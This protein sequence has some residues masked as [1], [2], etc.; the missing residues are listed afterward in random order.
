MTAPPSSP[1]GSRFRG[2]LP[3]AKSFRRA[4]FALLIGVIAALT[5]PHIM[6]EDFGVRIVARVYAPVAGWL[7]GT[8]G[9][10]QVSVLLIDDRSLQRAQ[11]SWPASYGYYA[12]LL[13]ALAQ[14]RP[15]A[16][17]IDVVFAAQ[18][19]DPSLSRLA[20]AT[21]RATAAGTRVYLAA[22]RSE[23][24]S[25]ALRP[26]LQALVPRCIQPVAI[27]YD[28]D[29][30]DQVAWSYRI[31]PERATGDGHALH[32]AAA[33]IYRDLGGRLPTAGHETLAL[34]W[35]LDPAA[36]GV[37]WLV[38]NAGSH[39]EHAATGH[40]A[41]HAG[42]GDH[43]E[44]GVSSYCRHPRHFLVETA[45][46]PALRK[47]AQED[48]FKP[49][50]VFHHTLYPADLAT[51]SQAEDEQLGA[52]LR[53][54]VVMVGTALQGSNDRVISPLHGSVP[55]VF[56]HAAALDN[57]L[58]YRDA[59]KRDMHLGWNR[60]MLLLL[61]GLF[62]M[63]MVIA[64]GEKLKAGLPK[65]TA[66]LSRPKQRFRA[67]RNYLVYKAVRLAAY[68]VF[69]TAMIVFGQTVFNLGMLTVADIAFFSF[70][71]EWLEWGE[72]LEEW[73]NREPA[74]PHTATHGTTPEAHD[75]SAVRADPGSA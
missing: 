13:D 52:R 23:T 66:N 45:V 60:T 3:T 39:D 15:R 28:P 10:D 42:H 2:L 11:Q 68:V 36:Q 19:D 64:G 34:N 14:Y 62:V 22:R 49:L 33:S 72:K 4:A 9:R 61:V 69:Y 59:Y 40:V 27:E 18:R 12:R 31:L 24:G 29:A 58:H 67:A 53:G 73:W 47:H 41:D 6:G 1:A 48:V 75:R 74:H 65:P 5:L 17:F 30:L 57:L 44:E 63:M 7:R 38:P 35:G 56:M 21:C 54:G 51:G 43:D 37:E 25:F 16:V 26:E 55:G 32:S 50:C 20:D 71:A 70:L 8:H 46:P